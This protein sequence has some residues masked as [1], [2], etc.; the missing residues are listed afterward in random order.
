[1]LALTAQIDG[2]NSAKDPFARSIIMTT[3]IAINGFGRIGRLVLRAL[4]DQNRTDLEIVAIND[5]GPVETNAHLLRFDSVHGRLNAEVTSGDEIGALVSAVNQMA[6]K[7]GGVVGEVRA[8]AFEAIGQY[9]PPVLLD[10]AM[11]G[12]APTITAQIKGVPAKAKTDV[13]AAAASAAAP[14]VPQ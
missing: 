10:A 11:S 12:M 5:L 2:S 13:L 14:A 8:A 3:T 6:E 7:L 4:L 9:G 1:M